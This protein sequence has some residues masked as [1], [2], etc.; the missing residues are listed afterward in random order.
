MTLVLFLLVLVSPSDERV[1]EVFLTSQECNQ[2]LPHHHL[3][4]GGS[5]TMYWEDGF[6]KEVK[7]RTWTR[8][9]DDD[10][11]KFYFTCRRAMMKEITQ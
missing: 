8:G 9:Y 11:S 3:G 2:R 4:F 1:E 5:G 6:D 10:P 7:F